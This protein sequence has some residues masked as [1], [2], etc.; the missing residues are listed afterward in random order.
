MI[1]ARDIDRDVY[2]LL[3]HEHPLGIHRDQLA[4]VLKT[5]DRT[6]R[7]AVERAR[8]LAATNPHPKLG[9]RI[10]GY[11]PETQR[12]VDAKTPDQALRIM[13]YY[14]TYVVSMLQPLRAQLDAYRSQYGELPPERQDMQQT[15]FDAES[16]G[17][18]VAHAEV[19]S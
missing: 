3:V 15:L 11:D 16:I 19:A 10:L 1:G 18:R 17:R 4:A 6:A 12:Y 2:R 13:A 8:M 9:V 7:G 5:D 14:H